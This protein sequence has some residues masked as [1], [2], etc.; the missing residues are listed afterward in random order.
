MFVSGLQISA[1]RTKQENNCETA[2]TREAHRHQEIITQ[3]D[4]N[5]AGDIVTTVLDLRFKKIPFLDAAV[6]QTTRK[7]IKHLHVHVPAQKDA[8][9]NPP[10][11][12]EKLSEGESSLW[13][14]FDQKV[15]KLSSHRNPETDAK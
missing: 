1:T 2:A 14:A 13:D 8:S 10:S 12:I 3:A 7:L 5:S 6:D 4:L 11:S 15:S 9:P